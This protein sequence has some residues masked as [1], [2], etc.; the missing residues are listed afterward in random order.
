MWFFE[1]HPNFCRRFCCQGFKCKDQRLHTKCGMCNFGGLCKTAL[2]AFSLKLVAGAQMSKEWK[3]NVVIQGAHGYFGVSVGLV[4][5]L[6]KFLCPT[7]EAR[8]RI[9]SDQLGLLANYNPP[10]PSKHQLC[11]VSVPEWMDIRNKSARVYDDD[12]YCSI[13]HDDV[14]DKYQIIQN[15]FLSYF[16]GATIH[17]VRE[18]SW[19]YKVTYFDYST[20]CVSDRLS[21][22]GWTTWM[23]TE[24]RSM[25]LW[26]TNPKWDEALLKY[27][28]TANLT[29][30][31]GRFFSSK[32][33]WLI[34]KYQ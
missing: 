29:V 4:D 15:I 10:Y 27:C 34:L 18:T 17:A 22:T 12:D 21:G 28:W 23:I 24:C 26:V 1:G 6:F 30:I 33:S 13:P 31:V 32:L 14:V 7:H 11:S 5:W 16:L 3:I 8:I 20:A 9:L 25:A 19:L 2:K